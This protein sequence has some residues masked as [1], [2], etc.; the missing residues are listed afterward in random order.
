MEGRV[1]VNR[2]EMLG[3]GL[4]GGVAAITAAWWALALWPLGADAPAWLAR[5]RW[6]CFGALPQGLPTAG[7]WIS[8]IGEPVAMTILL[9]VVWGDAVRAGIGMLW[10]SSGGRLALGLALGLALAGVGA[11]ANRVAQAANALP[12]L[13]ISDV[14]REDRAAPPLVLVD[15]TGRRFSLAEARG[16]PVLVTF[17]FGHCETVCPLVVRDVREAAAAVPEL[18]PVVVV[19]SLDPWRDLPTRLPAIAA[20][21]GLEPDAHVL[22]GSVAEVLGAIAA[23]GVTINRDERTGDITH[24]A[25]VFVLDRQGRIAFTAPGGRD[26]LVEL[27]QQ[28]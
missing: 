23:W 17:A 13:A 3:L 15:Q 10:H 14:V 1:G 16:R 24:P 12:P 22:G 18:A 2:R 5:T 7:G 27:L 26:V 11:A 20:G 9:L 21:W 19:V 28:I 4:L 25:I 8:L 6:V